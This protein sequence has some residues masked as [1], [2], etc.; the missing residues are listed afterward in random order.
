MNIFTKYTASH[1]PVG[2][3]YTRRAAKMV[4]TLYNRLRQVESDT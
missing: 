2:H 3:V 4:E 1:P